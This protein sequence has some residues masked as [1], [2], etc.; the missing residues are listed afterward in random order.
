MTK[1]T[2]IVATISDKRC[3]VDFIRQLYIEGINV[4]RMNSAQLQKE[5]FLRIINI[6]RFSHW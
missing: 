2:K 6:Y 5:G 3:D 4:V 1:Q